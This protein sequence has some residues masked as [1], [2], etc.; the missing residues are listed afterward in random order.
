MG[1]N[2]IAMGNNQ[3]ANGICPSPS[4]EVRWGLMF[5]GLIDLLKS[6]TKQSNLFLPLGKG[7]MGLE[8]RWGLNGSM[9][10]NNYCSPTAQNYK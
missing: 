10:S 7:R 4:G 3:I 2:Q 9:Q 5:I 8:D 6:L 1:N